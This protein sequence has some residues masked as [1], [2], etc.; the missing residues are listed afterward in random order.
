MDISS[1]LRKLIQIYSPSGHE[2]KLADFLL[3]YCRKN[4]L[5]AKQHDGNVILHFPG[6]KSDKALILNAH[7][8]T[9]TSG[10]LA[11]WNYPP[12]GKR[13]G[14]TV[15]GKIYGLGSSDDKGA[16]A[17]MIYLAQSFSKPPSDVWISFVCKEEMDGSGTKNFLTWFKQSKK[18]YQY[19]KIA[20]II[21]EP[22][23]LTSI[24]IGHRGNI[25]LQLETNGVTGHGAKEYTQHDLAT[26]KMFQSLQNLS[27]KFHQWKKEYKDALGVPS[28]NVTSFHTS[29]VSINKIP[30]SC[31]ALLDIRTTLRFHNQVYALV[32]E[33]VGKNGNVSQVKQELHPSFLSKK[34]SILHTAKTILSKV[35][36]TISMGSTDQ[37]IFLDHGIDAIVYGPGNK[38]V[39]HKEN[40][41]VSVEDCV[42]TAK[43]YDKIIQAF[44]KA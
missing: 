30:D 25:F 15:K 42:K 36:C 24:E 12:Y 21:G 35:D 43:I 16:I 1:F 34:S 31:L 5:P 7:M 6:N 17:S 23:N 8:D 20:A 22:T 14:K 41:Y 32:K 27:Q 3:E 44:A 4:N 13:A 37:A 19:K 28:F 39:I 2:E 40:E 10:N 9:V 26:E 18:F 11:S 38:D 29:D 33:V